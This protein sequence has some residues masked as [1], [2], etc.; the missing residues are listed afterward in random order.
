MLKI[1]RTIEESLLNTQRENLGYFYD[2]GVI[3]CDEHEFSLVY[4]E[5]EIYLAHKSEFEYDGLFCR[6]KEPINY[7]K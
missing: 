6:L 5:D 2:F 7:V 3:G 1:S 4:T